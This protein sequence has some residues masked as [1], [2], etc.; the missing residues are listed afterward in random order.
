MPDTRT[1]EDT[2]RESARDDLQRAVE[3]TCWAVLHGHKP[4]EGVEDFGRMSLTGV[5][6]RELEGFYKLWDEAMGAPPDDGQM[7]AI[8]DMVDGAFWYG[9]THAHAT[10]TGGAGLS[11][12]LFPALVGESGL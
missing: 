12:R 3:L 8:I 10:V 7:A 1:R 4:A 6:E 2:R 9:L 5:F 11:R